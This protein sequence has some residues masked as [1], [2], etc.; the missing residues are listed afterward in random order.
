[1]KEREMTMRKIK[2]KKREKTT[3]R[4]REES[5]WKKVETITKI[6]EKER[7]F[8]KLTFWMKLKSY[9]EFQMR[10]SRMKH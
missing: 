1:M 4:E 9:I 3:K 8:D 7:H 10:F 6:E 5:V 2:D